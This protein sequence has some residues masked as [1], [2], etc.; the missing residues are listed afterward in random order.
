MP[1]TARGCGGDEDVR[2]CRI[3]D[4][5]RKHIALFTLNASV[6]LLNLIKYRPMRRMTFSTDN[7][8]CRVAGKYETGIGRDQQKQ[9]K[10]KFRNYQKKSNF[11]TLSCYI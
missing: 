2:V 4:F 5:I 10:S 8:H 6:N 1:F 3:T 11:Q 9:F 7:H